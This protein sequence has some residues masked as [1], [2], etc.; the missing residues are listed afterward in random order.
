MTITPV[1]GANGEIAHF[2]AIK[3]DVSERRLLENRLQQ[4]QKMEAIGTLAG[5]IAHDFNNILAAMFGYAYLLQ[6]D[7]EGNPA[8]QENIGEILKATSRAKDLVQQILTFSRQRDLKRQV[9]RLDTV[10]REAMKFLRASLPADIKIEMHLAD[11]APAVLADPTQFYQVM[12]NLATNALHAMEGQAGKLT[13]TL[14]RFSPDG[15]FIQAHPDFRPIGYA[16][17]TIA[18]TGH[19][20][21]AKTQARIFEPFFTTKP[22]GK[23][24]GLGL[25]VVHGIIQSHDGVINVESQPGAGTTFL[26]YFPAQTDGAALTGTKVRKLHHGR[27]QRI[28]LV[29]DEPAL[30]GVFKQLLRRLNYQPTA[31]NSA[32]EALGWFR[33]NPAA[34]DL[35]I[36]DLTMPDISGL[37]FAREVRALRPEL[38]VVLATGYSSTLNHHDL[39]DAGI[40][41]LLE[42]PVSMTA[43]ADVLQ[44]VFGEP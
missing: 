34:F 26:I 22:V 15:K 23:G 12:I 19:G 18:D 41:E 37:E 42:K 8:A 6:Q 38:P 32:P 27:G 21:D 1:R 4:A 14:D 17:L 9:I 30:T 7:T 20:M 43:L 2:V 44:R 31:S 10:V 13:V 25:A 39:L 24:T 29:D 33:E 11:D 40:C 35:V 5:G 16:R 36:T 28:L 3:L